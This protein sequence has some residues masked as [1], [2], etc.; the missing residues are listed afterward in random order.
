MP[1]YAIH[2]IISMQR[3]DGIG[4]IC[5]D[6]NIILIEASD[7]SQAAD[8]VLKN[9]EHYLLAYEN[10][11]IDSVRLICKFEGIRKILSISN[12]F[13]H[14][15]KQNEKQPVSGSEITY[16]SY[17]IDGEDLLQEYMKGNSV[18]LDSID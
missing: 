1:W 10:L 11:E 9:Q 17:E 4:K 13:E 18:L 7:S 6:E 14:D 16:N 15:S 3:V 5:V 12:E 2:K 8:I